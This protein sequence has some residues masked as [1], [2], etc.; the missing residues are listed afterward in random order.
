MDEAPGGCCHVE[1]GCIFAKALL[2]RAAGCECSERRA[3]GERLAVDCV[4]PVAH[5]NCG[6]LA[7]LLRERARFALRLPA[8][9]PL[10]HQQALRLLCGGVLAL[11]GHL[12][13]EPEGPA[14][15]ERAALPDVHRLV[16]AAQER[17]GSLADLPWA[18]LV[19]EV[20]AWQPRRRPPGRER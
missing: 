11:H 12:R 20:A 10:T 7:A 16:R 3:L 19:P 17:H 18:A 13:A 14:A 2:A 4:S 8:S 1:H 6:T 9:G 15:G 5:T